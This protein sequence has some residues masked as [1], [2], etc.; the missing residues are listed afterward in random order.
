MM[1]NGSRRASERANERERE[2]ERERE[3]EKERRKGKK[4]RITDANANRFEDYSSLTQASISP[5]VFLPEADLK[6]RRVR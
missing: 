6:S 1:R 4:R 5:L 3:R 2:K